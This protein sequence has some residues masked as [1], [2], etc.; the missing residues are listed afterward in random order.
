MAFHNKGPYV[1]KSQFGGCRQSGDS[2]SD[3]NRIVPLKFGHDP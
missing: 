3:N 1:A 2:R